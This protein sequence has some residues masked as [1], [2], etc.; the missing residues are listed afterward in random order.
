MN[1]TAIEYKRGG[2]EEIVQR[3]FAPLAAGFPGAFGLADDCAALPVPPGHDLVVTTDPVIA[4]VHF[5]PDEDPANIAWKALAV[6]VSDLV[7]KGAAPLAYTMAVAFPERPRDAWLEAFARGLGNAQKAFGCHLAGGDT[8]RTPG[9]LT[10]SITA[11]GTLPAGALVRR[12]TARPGDVVYV[13]GT[14]GDA[15]L[16]LRLRQD[17]SLVSKWGL[18]SDQRAALESR[19]RAPTPVLGFESILRKHATAAIDV[20]DGLVKDFERLCAA[21]DV[22]GR[23]VVER[24]AISEAALAVVDAGGATL[25]ELVTGGEDY[26]LLIAVRPDSLGSDRTFERAAEAHGLR[27]TTIGLLKTHDAELPRVAVYLR[28]GPDDIEIDTPRTGWDHFKA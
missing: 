10:V 22:A 16:G 25:A 24:Q 9:P 5:L 13:T 2:E 7:A 15:A 12:S 14:I 1:A 27:V 21:S 28:T 11:F 6:N 19:H 17:P 20:S 26:E 18:S 4:G 3:H 23:L 8:D